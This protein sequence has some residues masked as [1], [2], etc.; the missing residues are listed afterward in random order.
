MTASFQEGDLV[1]HPKYHAGRVALCSEDE[2]IVEF[3][4]G[5]EEVFSAATANSSIIK[6]H[7]DGF[8]LKRQADEQEIN[9][10]ATE[11]P[12][13]MLIAITRDYSK[14]FKISI[15]QDLLRGSVVSESEWKN[16]QKRLLLTLS[17]DPRFKVEGA[18]NITYL[19]EVDE[20]SA[21]LLDRF[22]KAGTLK[23]KQRVCREFLKAGESGVPIDR[24][25]EAALDFFSGVV[26][27][28]SN[29]LGARLEALLF[30]KLLDA[31]VYDAI[32]ESLYSQIRAMSVV[33]CADAAAAI[34]DASLRREL[35]TLF[36]EL[37]PQDFVEIISTTI[38]RFNRLRNWTLDFLLDNDRDTL[39]FL[40]EAT[41]G[42][43]STNMGVF[44]WL[45]RT[46]LTSAEKLAFLAVSV[47]SIVFELL[48]QLS[49]THLTGA[50]SAHPKDG[51]YVSRE[52]GEMLA[53]LEDTKILVKYLEKQDRQFKERFFQR[54]LD[55]S[56]IDDDAKNRLRNEL[57]RLHPDI[58]A[59]P[60]SREDKREVYNITRAAYE[61]Y[62][63]ELRTL[64]DEKIPINLKEIGIAREWGDLS[65]NAEY[66]VARDKQGILIGRKLFLE[67]LLQNCK[68]ID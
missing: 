4:S 55:C 35:L 18:E 24:N 22:R 61:K 9:R 16:W 36:R 20:I 25:R 41:L 7:P 44:L 33:E 40:V 60:V 37:K 2:F 66:Q 14:S 12:T 62:Q 31:A 52:E 34:T 28:S 49:K 45:S 3:D 46:L 48:S 15:L 27:S 58:A 32:K 50:F 39:V 57:E 8:H 56:A 23:E 67:K 59:A 21:E 53:L 43:V 68:I 10:L 29:L 64:V 47:D 51:P 65:E 63:E 11:E 13:S 1:Y 6:L 38:K 17:H 42:D 26:R 5:A 54:Y 19:G 30:I